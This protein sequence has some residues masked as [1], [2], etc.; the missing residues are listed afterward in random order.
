MKG[1]HNTKQLK[2]L[3][4]RCHDIVPV[5]G[6][7]RDSDG[8][9][10]PLSYRPRNKFDPQPWTVCGY[11]YSSAELYARPQHAPG[12]ADAAWVEQRHVTDLDRSDA[13]F[14]HMFDREVETNTA[15]VAA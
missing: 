14:T 8:K 7:L 12:V 10:L 1:T 3:Q 9:E 11:H 5:F 6:A 2:E 13:A 4:V 15:G